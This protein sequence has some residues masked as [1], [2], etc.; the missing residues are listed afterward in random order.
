MRFAC[1][2]IRHRPSV[3]TLARFVDEDPRQRCPVPLSQLAGLEAALLGVSRLNLATA[4]ERNG[5]RDKVVHLHTQKKTSREWE[6]MECDK[7]WQYKI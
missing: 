6:E 5:A 1:G 7:A 2:K 3:F 4:L